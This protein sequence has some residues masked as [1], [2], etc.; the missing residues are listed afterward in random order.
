MD[1]STIRTVCVVALI[2]CG[3]GAGPAA[4]GGSDA[5]Q[6]TRTQPAASAN[7][8]GSGTGGVQPGL[9]NRAPQANGSNGPFDL[10]I[11]NLTR[12]GVNCRQVTVTL[13]NA[14]DVTAEN[15]TVTSTVLAGDR[16]VVVRRTRIDRLP[17]NESVTRTIT[18]SVGLLDVQAIQRNG[19]RITVRTVVSSDQHTQRFV[20]SRKVL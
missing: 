14:G 18:V 3:F 10:S 8:A 1:R 13:S 9:T 2:V 20:S 6:V 15:V 16:T 4:A 5:T 11:R 19:G 17:P 7:V 12:C